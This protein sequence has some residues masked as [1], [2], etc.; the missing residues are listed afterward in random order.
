[1]A[2]ETKVKIK[3]KSFK[4]LNCV[5][6]IGDEETHEFIHVPHNSKTFITWLPAKLHS[7]RIVNHKT[8]TTMLER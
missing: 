8:L 2:G 7:N 3:K 4:L 1:M 5:I 6:H